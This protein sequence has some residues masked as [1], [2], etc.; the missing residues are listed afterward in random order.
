MVRGSQMS[1]EKE[2]EMEYY[3][4]NAFSSSDK[5]DF[6]EGIRAQ[7]IDKDSSPKWRHKS[8]EEVKMEEVD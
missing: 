4:C 2:L 8:V 5:S 7:L 6:C 3:L 1:F